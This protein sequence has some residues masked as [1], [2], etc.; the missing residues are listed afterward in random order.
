M[1]RSLLPAITL[2]LFFSSTSGPVSAC[3]YDG[4]PVDLAMAH[5]GS[6]D[7]AL[8][9]HDAYEEGL[10]VRPFPLQGGF[11]M[12]RALMML[13]KLRV[14]LAPVMGRERFDLLLVEP[15]LWTRFE[16]NGGVVTMTAHARG[17][18]KEQPVV[19]VGEG[20]L[21]ALMSGKLGIDQALAKGV[22]RIDV[23]SQRNEAM[24]QRWRQAF[25]AA[26]A[27]NQS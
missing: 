1:K 2:I 13:E 14:A 27:G 26:L 8:A 25:A 5:P 12:R 10:F 9:I 23:G 20:V 22:L 3:S 18:D 16:S 6:L 24:A 4:R 7:V 11:G 21:M 15:G 19:I 17:P